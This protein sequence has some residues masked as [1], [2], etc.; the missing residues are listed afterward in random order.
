LTTAVLGRYAAD[1]AASGLAGYNFP[2][3]FGL[4]VAVTA[5]SV[6]LVGATVPSN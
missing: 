6:A 4:I 2:L 1:L 5:L 3:V